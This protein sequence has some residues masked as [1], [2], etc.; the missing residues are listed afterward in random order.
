MPTIKQYIESANVY[1]K[2]FLG[3]IAFRHENLVLPDGSKMA[4]G[5]DDG[6]WVLVYQGKAGSTFKVY[7]YNQHENSMAVDQ[8]PGNDEDK[9]HMFK[10]LCYFFAQAQTDDLVTILPPEVL[11]TNEGNLI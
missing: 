4:L 11:T 10:L 9:K 5:I 2:N 8:K 7:N 6:H 1:D 3:T